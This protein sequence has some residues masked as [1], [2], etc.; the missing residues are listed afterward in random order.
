MEQDSSI[1]A[2]DLYCAVA[3]IHDII[4]NLT[5]SP[6]SEHL[7]YVN[8]NDA[9]FQ[10]RVGRFQPMITMMEQLGYKMKDSPRGKHLC[11]EFDLT[12]KVSLTSGNHP[13][14]RL[15]QAVVMDLSNATKR[16][17]PRTSIGELIITLRKSHSGDPSKQMNL[18]KILSM[19]EKALEKIIEQP[20]D[21][22]FQSISLDKINSKYPDVKGIT[23]LLKLLGFGRSAKNLLSKD[24]QSKQVNNVETIFQL[25]IND[26]DLLRL[27]RDMMVQIINSTT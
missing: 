18:E 14:I 27:R 24:D 5:I 13:Q 1:I 19:L 22:N 2:E 21:M 9:V 3:T 6:L 8:V 10:Q 7:R 12:Y 20:L 17:L 23:S 11:F 15:L 26:F 4:R 25:N 16:I